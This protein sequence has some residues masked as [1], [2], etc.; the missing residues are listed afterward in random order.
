MPDFKA[1]RVRLREAAR[2]RSA[3]TECEANELVNVD[4][5]GFGEGATYFVEWGATPKSS[6]N[7]VWLAE[8]TITPELPEV[9]RTDYI[10][11]ARQSNGPIPANLALTGASGHQDIPPGTTIHIYLIGNI[12]VG[13]D[14]HKFF[15]FERTLVSE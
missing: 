5:S 6:A 1:A 13:R 14:P 15:C 4:I 10:V 7:S 8:M 3:G 12:Q 9:G 11:Q 2:N